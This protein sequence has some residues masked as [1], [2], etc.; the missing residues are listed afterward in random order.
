MEQV[1]VGADLRI[2]EQQQKGFEDME[3]NYLDRPL[4]FE[5]WDEATEGNGPGA[6]EQKKGEQKLLDDSDE[7]SQEKEDA[8]PIGPT[9]DA[10]L[11]MQ[12]AETKFKS[13]Y[14]LNGFI[15]LHNALKPA[16]TEQ[17]FQL[18]EEAE[19]SEE[20]IPSDA[21]LEAAAFSQDSTEAA[22]NRMDEREFDDVIL[23]S[24]VKQRE[25]EE[26][27]V[28]DRPLLPPLYTQVNLEDFL[29][30]QQEETKKEKPSILQFDRQ[31]RPEESKRRTM[32][33]MR[34][35]NLKSTFPSNKNPKVF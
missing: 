12:E 33:V 25:E 9:G 26:E 24:E 19:E 23:H 2:G 5:E 21:D 34:L 17:Q 18:E 35:R 20:D 22:L 14:Q 4:L 8:L 7:Q 3:R 13:R 29:N 30:Q 11:D 31:L 16:S 15:P 32:K 10:D 27:L 1:K 28:Y 6:F